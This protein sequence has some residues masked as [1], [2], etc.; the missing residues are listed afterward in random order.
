MIEMRRE[1]ER[2]R[3]SHDE[4]IEKLIEGNRVRD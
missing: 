3:E 4:N 1:E 2:R